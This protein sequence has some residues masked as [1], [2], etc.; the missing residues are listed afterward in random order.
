MSLRR[1]MTFAGSTQKHTVKGRDKT[2]LDKRE[3]S[4]TTKS[5]LCNRHFRNCCLV[6][7]SVNAKDVS[8]MM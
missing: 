2:S 1:T 4:A 5:F 3:L 7:V 6:R 8:Q